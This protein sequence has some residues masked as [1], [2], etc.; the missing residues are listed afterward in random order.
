MFVLKCNLHKR[1]FSEPL[2]PINTRVYQR[3]RNESNQ[4]VPCDCSRKSDAPFGPFACYM[5]IRLAEN[6]F[7][8]RQKQ[9][10][11]NFCNYCKLTRK[12]NA[13]NARRGKQKRI[14]SNSH[15]MA[16]CRQFSSVQTLKTS[17][18][19]FRFRWFRVSIRIE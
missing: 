3:H 13:T 6:C 14:Q 5:F 18:R 2:C 1:N 7:V 10:P 8:K 4:L 17:C 15:V 11:L 12:T 19:P 9:T 16:G